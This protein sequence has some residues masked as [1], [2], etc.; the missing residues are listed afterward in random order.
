VAAA[1][2]VAAAD[3]AE[4]AEEA[5]FKKNQMR[6]DEDPPETSKQTNGQ[7]ESVDGCL[8]INGK[9]VPKS[10]GDMPQL[11]TDDYRPLPAGY[12]TGQG[13]TLTLVHFSAQSTLNPNPTPG[14]CAA[15]SKRPLLSST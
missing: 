6:S 1:K 7:A 4:E 5:S 2:E 14:H 13:L 9:A 12:G 3:A 10:W 15:Y 11:Q 8:K